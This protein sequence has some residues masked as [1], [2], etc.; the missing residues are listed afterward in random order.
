MNTTLK[1]NDV[2][3]LTSGGPP[4]TIESIDAKGEC[5]CRWFVGTKSNEAIFSQSILK[6]CDD[7]SQ[8]T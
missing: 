2:V 8:R 4:M 1:V 5:I 7:K 3:Q 6:L